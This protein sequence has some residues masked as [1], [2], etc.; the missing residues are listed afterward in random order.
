MRYWLQSWLSAIGIALLLAVTASGECVSCATGRGIPTKK[1]DCCTPDGRCKMPNRKAP[2]TRCV[3]SHGEQPV[4]IEKAMQ[5]TGVAA[6]SDIVEETI[7]PVTRAIE[8][9]VPFELH[10]SPPDLSVLHSVFLI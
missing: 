5:V 10:Y 3:K 7:E 1:G 2:D 9:S 4:I 6:V 8:P